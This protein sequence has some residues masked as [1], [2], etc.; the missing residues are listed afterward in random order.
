MNRALRPAFGAV[1][2]GP[3]NERFIGRWIAEIRDV[4][5]MWGTELAGPM[6]GKPSPSLAHDVPFLSDPMR[7]R[8]I[9]EQAAH[10]IGANQ[11]Q[12]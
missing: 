5:P 2:A 9:A 10:R 3:R 4:G 12:V 8:V 11:A 1:V 7:R 6:T